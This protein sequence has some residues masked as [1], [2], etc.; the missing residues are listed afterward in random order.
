MD[1][2]HWYIFIRT[3]KYYRKHMED[4]LPKYFWTYLRYI[5]TCLFFCLFFQFLEI[6]PLLTFFIFQIFFFR[7]IFGSQCLVPGLIWKKKRNYTFSFLFTVFK[8][9]FFEKRITFYV[10]TKLFILSW[11]NYYLKENKNSTKKME[12]KIIFFWKR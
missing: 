1:I 9:S 8:L 10:T 4:K 5:A 2:Y 3:W 11:D 7:L 12:N 6:F